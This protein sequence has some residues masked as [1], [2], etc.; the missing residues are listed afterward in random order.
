MTTATLTYE[1]LMALDK[2]ARADMKIARQNGEMSIVDT[3]AGCVD[4]SYDK[5]SRL[6]RIVS[7][8]VVPQIRLSGLT[9]AGCAGR[10]VKLYDVVFA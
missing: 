7:R 5:D 4:L 1:Q 10:L 2:F 8:G 3:K 6:Y 9:S